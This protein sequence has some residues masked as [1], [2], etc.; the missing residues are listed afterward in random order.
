MAR[1][2]HAF[3]TLPG[4]S[5]GA[6]VGVA[7]GA[8]CALAAAQVLL[9]KPKREGHDLFSSEKP[10]AVRGEKRRSVEEERALAA[11]TAAAGR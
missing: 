9:R 2:W 4:L 6:K 11:R 8:V 5:A 7:A 1:L 10:E 3:E